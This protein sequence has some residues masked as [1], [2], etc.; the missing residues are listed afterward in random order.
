M[1]TELVRV[2]L[3]WSCSALFYQYS[4]DIKDRAISDLLANFKINLLVMSESPRF[5]V[6][7]CSVC[8]FPVKIIL[9]LIGI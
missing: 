3:A 5:E 7:C 9:E 8:Y 6:L 2:Y 1:Q 4:A